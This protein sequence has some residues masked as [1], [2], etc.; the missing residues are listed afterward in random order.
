[1]GLSV[2][3]LVAYYPCQRPVNMTLPRFQ[4]AEDSITI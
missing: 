3:L 2:V 4:G 1:M